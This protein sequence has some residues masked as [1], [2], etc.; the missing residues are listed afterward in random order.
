[1]YVADPNSST[2]KQDNSGGQ[3]GRGEDYRTALRVG[4]AE[5]CAGTGAVEWCEDCRK[6]LIVKSSIF[7]FKVKSNR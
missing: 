7:A 4:R 2:A 1:M 6:C 3:G 5:T